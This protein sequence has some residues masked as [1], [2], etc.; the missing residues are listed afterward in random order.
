MKVLLVILGLLAAVLV[1]IVVVGA[2]LPKEHVVSRSARYQQPPEVI[3]QTINDYRAFPS[4]RTDVSRVEPIAGTEGRVAW[5]EFS[6]HGAIPFEIVEAQPPSTLVTRIA[7]PNLP[8][9][10]TWTYQIAPAEGGSVLTI[11][12]HGEVYNPVFRFISRFFI[13]HTAT[14]DQYLL[15]LG[16]KFGEGVTP[17]AAE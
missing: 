7:D 2:L 10:G 16:R 6:R 5:K 12:E 11:T 9:G 13:G 4:W 15:A 8:F 14:A 17:Q 1:L 3:W